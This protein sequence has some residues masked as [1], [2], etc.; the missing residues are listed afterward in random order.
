MKSAVHFEKLSMMKLSIIL[1][2]PSVVVVTRTSNGV[3]ILN[4]KGAKS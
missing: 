1:Y 2:G 3:L 4:Y